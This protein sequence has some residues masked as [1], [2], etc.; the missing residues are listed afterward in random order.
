MSLSSIQQIGYECEIRFPGYVEIPSGFQHVQSGYCKD[1]YFLLVAPQARIRTVD[2]THPKQIK[3]YF[4]TYKY[5]KE[6]SDFSQD[7]EPVV[8]ESEPM[9]T[10]QDLRN[11]KYF[12]QGR[13]HK[14]I[15]TVEGLRRTYANASGMK[16]CLDDI[17]GLGQY[18]ELEMMAQNQ[19]Q[20][21]VFQDI[22]RYTALHLGVDL[23]RLETRTYPDIFFEK[24][25]QQDILTGPPPTIGDI[26][27]KYHIPL[28]SYSGYVERACRNLVS[29]CIVVRKDGKYYPTGRGKTN[30][31][32]KG[33]R[34]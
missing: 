30:K 33:R 16:I 3:V 29:Q 32:E 11:A 15:L 21:R 17:E 19:E 34:S 14:R 10:D 31:R 26:A 24:L 4:M 20:A 6:G 7:S 22:I 23:K 27:R 9:L 18:T 12:M 2:M 1:E 28:P 25:V 8:W 13:R 5:Q